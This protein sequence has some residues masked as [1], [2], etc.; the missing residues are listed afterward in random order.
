MTESSRDNPWRWR[1]IAALIVFFAV[2]AFLFGFEHRAH[3]LAGET[4]LV[5]LLL[6]FVGAH[7][8]FGAGTDEPKGV[9]H[10]R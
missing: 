3:V 6:A 4:A 8:F 10:D 9:R 2:A 1:R 7:L 5:V